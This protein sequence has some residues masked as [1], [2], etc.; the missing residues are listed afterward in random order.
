MALIQFRTSTTEWFIG[1]KFISSSPDK[2]DFIFNHEDSEKVRFT[3]DGKVGIGTDAP[4]QLLHVYKAGVLEPNFQSTTGRVGLQLNAGAA[5]DVSW[6]LYS[7]YPAAGD[8]NIRE[9]GVAN[10]FVI[11]K[12]TGY[13]GV[14][15]DTPGNIL[16]VKKSTAGTAALFEAGGTNV[17]VGL[18]ESGG[19]FTY[20]GND[21]GKML[22]Q[23]SGSSYSTKLIIQ[24]DGNVGIGTVT[25]GSLL[26]V[27]GNSDDGDGACTIAINDEDS[28]VGSKLPAIQFYGGGTTQGRIRGGDAAFQIAVGSSP[29]TA[30]NINTA[31]GY[32][33]FTYGS[34]V[35]LTLGSTGTAET[36]TANWVRASGAN[37][38]FNAASGD[39]NWEV[40]GVHR[41]RLTDTGFLGIG[42]GAGTDPFG[43]L[44]VNGTN[45]SN[46][47]IT[48]T[49]G[50]SNPTNST[51]G[52][53][54]FGNTNIDSSCAE[55]TGDQ[56]GTNDSGRLEFGT[57]ASV[58]GGV[59]TRMTIKGDGN[60]GI[61]TVTPSRLLD[62]NGT[63]YFR[64]DIYFGNTVLNP[65]SGFSNQTGMGWDKSIGQLQIAANN[66]TALE[67]G[68]HTGTGTVFSVRY[69]STQKA[70]IDTSGNMSLAGTLT[71]ASSLALKENIEDFTPSLDIIN[72]IRPVKYNKKKESKKEIGLIAEE[73][74]ELF[75]ELVDRDNQGNPSG[76]NYSRAVA[77]LLGGFK[78][79]Y[80]EIEE[81][82]KRI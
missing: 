52:S 49:S 23:T 35:R 56:D 69:A 76:V 11:K 21:A 72:K 51:F 46:I 17:F 75:P 54:I 63:A 41:M 6:I 61:G 1:N 59:V 3:N 80:K 78:E 34:Q 39:F 12:T 29:T 32:P 22:F 81:L 31:N 36:N 28:T 9:S 66:T 19:N 20:I 26:S 5:G 45:G 43:Q 24:T 58:V 55:I 64:D 82:K 27:S 53:I 71:E 47:H 57:Q 38:E 15:T 10:H 30:L 13:V 33:S 68:R 73:L 7:G 2:S 8:F 77:V 37:L 50:G 16:H 4:G 67:V 48:R 14:G 74:A 70:S 44:H 79:L 40:G 60:V 18:K 62:V 25:P 42:L 65:A